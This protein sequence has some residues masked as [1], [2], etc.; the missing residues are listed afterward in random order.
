MLQSQLKSVSFEMKPENPDHLPSWNSGVLQANQ[1]IQ[2][3][4]GFYTLKMLP[5]GV[6]ALLD[7]TDEVIW[8][9][10][11][12]FKGKGPWRTVMQDDGNLVIYASDN[13]AKWA[14]NSGRG[15]GEYKLVLQDDRNM[16]I[17]TRD[18]RAIWD[19]NTVFLS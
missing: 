19:T 7:R 9:G 4:N 2:S 15:R 14:S 1:F 8:K 3:V 17:Y 13:T 16:V 10:G 5:D 18:G 6:L 12:P 11:V